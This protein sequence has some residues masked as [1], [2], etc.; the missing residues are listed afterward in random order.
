M[1]NQLV[2]VIES[3]KADRRLAS[4]DEPEIKQNIV[5]RILS[6]LGWDIFNTYEVYLDERGCGRALYSLKVNGSTKVFIEVMHP[7][8]EIKI[9]ERFREHFLKE[10]YGFVILT[11]G[12][13][14]WFHFAPLHDAI[15]WD[16]EKFYTIDILYQGSE[17]IASRFSDFLSRENVASGN[18]LIN[19]ETAS[20]SE[21]RNLIVETLPKAWDSIIEDADKTLIELISNRAERLCGY[22][23]GAEMVERFLREHKGNF[24][25][26]EPSAREQDFALTTALSPSFKEN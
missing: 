8:E 17:D 6:M 13:T 18:A 7:R 16:E 25:I 15:R 19:A 4:F 21:Q 5:L 2:S 10:K 3:L 9:Y 23:V 12:V 24:R 14:W 22:K 20:K 11:N 26:S 1:R